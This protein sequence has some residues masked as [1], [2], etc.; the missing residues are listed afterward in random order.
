MIEYVIITARPETAVPLRDE[1]TRQMGAG[2][3]VSAYGCPTHTGVVVSGWTEAP[4][5]SAEKFATM[6]RV[7]G[8]DAK[9]I[10]MSDFVAMGAT[11][12]MAG[13]L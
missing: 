4:E 10:S 5:G 8:L 9:V 3:S 6:L 2:M 7:S 11:T 12:L 13:A 1:I